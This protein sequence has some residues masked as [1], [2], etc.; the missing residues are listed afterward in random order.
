[1]A[2]RGLLVDIGPLRR[3]PLF[4]RLWF[5]YLVT[6]L[7]N[8]LTVVAVAFEV[9]KLTHSSLDVGL[10]SLAQLG[11]LLVGSLFGGSIADA[12]DRRKLLLVTQVSLAMCSAGLTSDAMLRHPEV[13]PLFLVSAVAA[14]ISSID[15]PARAAVFIGLV[16][17]DDYVSATALWQLLMQLG[18]VV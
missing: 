6:T 8:Q 14:G 17:R 12:V 4:R 2:R 5:G 11:P 1:M 3:Y 16:G 18:V 7:G 15:Q 13:W 10:V 9:F